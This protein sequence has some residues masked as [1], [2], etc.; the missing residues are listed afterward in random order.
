M[1]VT[2][3]AI[4]VTTEG[5]EPDLRPLWGAIE[6]ALAKAMRAAHRATRPRHTKGDIKDA[7]YEVMEEAYLKAAG[8]SAAWPTRARSTTSARPLVQEILGPEAELKDKYFTQNLLPDFIA[9]HPELTADW[10]V[11]YDA[12]GHLIEPHTGDQHPGRHAAGA[13]LPAAAPAPAADLVTVDAALYPTLGPENRFPT[14][15]YIEKEGF[16]PLLRKARIAERFD[17]AIMS[18]KGMSVTAA[19]L[20][21]DRY[22]Q[23]GVRVLVAHDFDR[24]GACI[25]RT[26]GNDTRRY[27]F[28]AD[29]D[30]VDLG[31]SLAEARGD[32]PAGRGRARPGPGEDKLREYGLSEEEIDFLIRQG[33]AS[34]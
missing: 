18:T 3:P 11:V 21:V 14:L 33:V 8:G 2:S 34:S 20:I 19:R 17:C 10:D 28:E 31:L 12:R 25:A 6:P 26:L 1:A 27:S 23:Q 15:L 4:P 24:S 5:K 29:P 32:G 13:R 16:E 22:A 7:A 30:V 9:E